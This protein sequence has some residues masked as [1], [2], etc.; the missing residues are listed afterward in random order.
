VVEPP[1]LPPR[2]SHVGTVAAAGTA[3]WLVGAVILLVAWAVAGRPLGIEFTTC[4][5]G[6][7][8]GGFGYGVYSWQR[9]AVRRGS[10]SAQQ[11]LE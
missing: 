6:A 1:S 8:L 2:L 7:L 5:A 9:A 11:G 10:R 3:L 4:V